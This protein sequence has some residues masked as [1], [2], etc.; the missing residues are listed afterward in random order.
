MNQLDKGPQGS[1]VGDH[2]PQPERQAGKG[3]PTAGACRRCGGAIRGRRR[4]GYCSD[5]CR[6]RDL[7]QAGRERLADGQRR[8]QELL[9]RI[10]KAVEDLQREVL[11]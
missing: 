7:R 2:A 3:N 11:S 9:D 6:M 5:T 8:R 10:I 4:N 1:T